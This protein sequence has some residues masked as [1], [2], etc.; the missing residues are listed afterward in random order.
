[1][2]FHDLTLGK[3][4]ALERR[5]C[6]PLTMREKDSLLKPCQCVSKSQFIHLDCLKSEVIQTNRDTCLECNAK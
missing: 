6:A 3:R 5:A 1:M 2:N 4:S